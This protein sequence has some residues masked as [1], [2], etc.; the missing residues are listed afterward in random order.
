[1]RNLVI[2]GDTAF[3]ERLLAYIK[4]ESVD[5]V[6]A[7]TQEESFISRSYIQGIKVLSF[8]NLNE[9]L[10]GIDFEIILGIGY[11]KMNDLRERVFNRCVSQGYKVASYISK[12]ALC[13]TDQ[14]GEGTIVLPGSLIGP[15]CKIGISNF[16]ES[17]CAISHDSNIGNFN[18]F[19]TN[20]VIG[21]HA[22]VN[23]HCFVG[24]HSTVINDI[25]LDDYT[26]I[27]ASS[28]VIRSTKSCGLYV[29][30]PA[31]LLEGKNPKDITI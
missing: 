15:G 27:G 12:N 3:S 13:Y 28:N 2:F 6:V 20:V 9:L 30:N 31:R 18:F 29:G 23:N 19:S 7:F 21:G 25:E 1:M 17:S 14:I 22:N 11:T 16:F 5:D 26:F 24:L 8:E 4:H 10:K